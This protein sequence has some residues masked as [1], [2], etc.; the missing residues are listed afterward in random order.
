MALA[1]AYLPLYSTE[2]DTLDNTTLYY[3]L[4]PSSHLGVFHMVCTFLLVQ[5]I[6]VIPRGSSLAAFCTSEKHEQDAANVCSSSPQYVPLQYGFTDGTKIVHEIKLSD[7]LRRSDKCS[8]RLDPQL[9]L[10]CL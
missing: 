6:T 2:V 4:T 3:V 7:R 8:V 5:A 10:D 9:L 1:V